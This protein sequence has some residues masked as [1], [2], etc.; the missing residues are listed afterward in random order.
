MKWLLLKTILIMDDRSV[1]DL[2]A[3]ITRKITIPSHIN[4]FTLK[5]VIQDY[6]GNSACPSIDQ[7]N[8]ASIIYTSGTTGDLKGVMLS[9]NNFMANTNSIPVLRLNL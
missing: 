4:F 1:K 9:H 7:R 6:E 5:D 2:L 8:I 3:F